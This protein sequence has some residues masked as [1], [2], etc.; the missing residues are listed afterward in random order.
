MC[1]CNIEDQTTQHIL[2]RYPNHTNINKEPTMARQHHSATETLWTS[3]A[4]E[5]Y[6]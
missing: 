1:I 2:H 3:R 5:E 6:C 4:T